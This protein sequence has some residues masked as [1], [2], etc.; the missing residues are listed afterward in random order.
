MSNL[1]YTLHDKRL[2]DEQR[3]SVSRLMTPERRIQS[4][5]IVSAGYDEPRLFADLT[6]GRS[7]RI[8]PNGHAWELGR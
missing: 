8:D 1:H 2:S 3:L 6:N 7:I 4:A 5:R